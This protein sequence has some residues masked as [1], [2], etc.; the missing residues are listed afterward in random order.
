MSATPG[1]LCNHSA[2]GVCPACMERAEKAG[3]ERAIAEAWRMVREAAQAAHR[4][5]VVPE[6]D[7]IELLN[8]KLA[9]SASEVAHT[10][11]AEWLESQT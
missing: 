11:I 7:A 4:L 6:H 9:A 3:R 8:I 5:H 1:V 2:A 10:H